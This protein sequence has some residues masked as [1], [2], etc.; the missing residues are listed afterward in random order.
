MR[1]LVLEVLLADSIVQVIGDLWERYLRLI[2]E[3][4]SDGYA[5]PKFPW[6]RS[7]SYFATVMRWMSLDASVTAVGACL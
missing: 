5:M 6:D 4:K 2:D 7:H 3:G 1:S